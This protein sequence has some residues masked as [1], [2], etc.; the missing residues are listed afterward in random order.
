[1][2][3][4]LLIFDLDGT[5]INSKKDIIDAFNFSFVKNNIQPISLSFFLK[6]SSL[7]SSYLIKK[8]VKK[9]YYEKLATIKKDF[10][11]YYSINYAKTTKLKTGVFFFLKWSSRFYINVISTNK[12]TLIAKKILKRFKIDKY[13]DGIYGCDYFKYKKPD[14]RH[15][16]AVLKK[17]SIKKKNAIF[18]GDSQIDSEMCKKSKVFF[19]LLEHGYTALNY[20][21]IYKN[22]MIKDFNKARVVV[23]KKAP[24]V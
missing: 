10:E 17:H 12:K 3:K 9:S 13:I 21:K 20:K 6:N 18:F 1:M 7:G 11:K 4:K 2:K 22:F 24:Y 14:K 23:L 8:N 19:V 16:F 15:L 5:L